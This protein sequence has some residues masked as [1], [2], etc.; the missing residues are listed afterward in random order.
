MESS[1]LF[2]FVCFFSSGLAFVF[3]SF[4]LVYLLGVLPVSSSP[5]GHDSD[6]TTPRII[7]VF[8]LFRRGRFCLCFFLVLPIFLGF[9]RLFSY[10]HTYI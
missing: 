10:V 3:C 8:V 4:F 9:L 5:G 1:V 2:L 6:A 7:F